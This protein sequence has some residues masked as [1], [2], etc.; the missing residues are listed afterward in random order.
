MIQK[1]EQQDI[2]F[3][4]RAPI[5]PSSGHLSSWVLN[6]IEDD[7]RDRLWTS[8][9]LVDGNADRPLGFKIQL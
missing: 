2:D 9:F 7:L 6:R 8:R 3:E 4:G 5:E 1:S